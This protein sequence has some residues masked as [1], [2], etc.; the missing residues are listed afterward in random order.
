MVAASVAVSTADREDVRVREALLRDPR[1]GW[2][3]PAVNDYAVRRLLCLAAW[4]MPY[5]ACASPDVGPLFAP[6]PEPTSNSNT[7]FDECET[8]GTDID[9][10]RGTINEQ[11]GSDP[12]AGLDGSDPAD[13]VGCVE[14]VCLG[15]RF[16]CEGSLLQRC[17]DERNAWLDFQRCASAQLC[18]ATRGTEGCTPPACEAG[19][20]SCAGDTLVRCRDESE[21]SDPVA[22]CAF[23]GG[24]D[25]LALVCRDPCVIGGA[26]CRGAVLETCDSVLV[27]W[28]SSACAT[29]E[30]CNAATRS[31]EQPRCEPEARG[32]R[33]AQPQ[34]CARGGTGLVDIGVPCA[35]AELCDPS[36]GAC[37]EPACTVGQTACEGLRTLLTC[38]ASQT[39]FDAAPCDT[40]L[41]LCN[42]GPPAACRSL[43]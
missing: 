32:C 33:G 8:G 10:G 9:A 38:N 41:A 23:A 29:P 28:Q 7:R 22:Q 40:L 27:G 4:C 11:G 37:L 25:P 5:L 31:C 1:Q 13:A 42:P 39:G 34:R 35:S 43:L 12:L 26:R 20:L 19:V 14:P 17:S 2:M 15:G 18:D 36:S 24:C 30:L 16:R 6:A 3:N 21:G